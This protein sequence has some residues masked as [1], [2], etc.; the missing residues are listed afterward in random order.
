[1]MIMVTSLVVLV[2]V[3]LALQ[4]KAR[5]DLNTNA[6]KLAELEGHIRA[7]IS[8][9]LGM[10][11][12]LNRVASDVQEVELQRLSM[13][14]LEKAEND[15][16]YQQASLLLTRGAT[17]EEVVDTCDIAPAEAEL[18]AV[19]SHSVGSNKVA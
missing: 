12:K 15:K 1:M 11:K 19:L 3:L 16:N 18:I 4:F 9:N 6:K 14:S 2:S 7:I 10:G 5:K 13:G 17:I 8:G